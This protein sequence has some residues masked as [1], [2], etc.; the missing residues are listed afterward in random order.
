[1]TFRLQHYEPDTYAPVSTYGN[2]SATLEQ[3]GT[4]KPSPHDIAEVITEI[5]AGKLPDINEVGTAGSFFKN[6][7]L[8]KDEYDDFLVK[9]HHLHPDLRAE[10]YALEG[11][12]YKIPTGRI[13]DQVLGHRGDREGAVG[14]WENQALCLVNYG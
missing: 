6:V 13:L 9:L 5:R 14:C 1:M 10:S 11:D 4:T 8:S 7:I 3:R 2:I 12:Y